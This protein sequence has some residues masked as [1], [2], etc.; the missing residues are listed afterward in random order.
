[1]EQPQKLR[2]IITVNEFIRRQEKLTG[3][4][5][6]EFSGLLMD[7]ILASKIVH[8]EVNKAGLVNILGTEGSANVSGDT[9]MKLDVFANEQFLAALE[10]GGHCL[11]AAS[12]ELEGIVCFEGGRQRGAR[13]IVALDPLDGSSNIDVNVSIGTIF[14]VFRVD[15]PGKLVTEKDFLRPGK[16]LVAAGY[17]LYGS[18]TMLVFTT[19]QS[20][21]GFTLDPSLGEYCLSHPEIRTPEVGSIYSVNEANLNDMPEGVKNYLA[22]CK[23]KN[24]PAGKVHT[25][26]Y[27][28]SLVADFHRN[29]LKGGIYLY[30]ATAKDP[31]GKLRLLYECA[32]LGFICEQAGGRA[33]DGNRSVLE[34]KPDTL[35]QRCPLFIGSAAMVRH[36]ESFL[37]G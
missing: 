21:N 16:E 29:L 37:N 2:S 34:L 12:E 13:Y 31:Q 4:A 15:E 36:A 19:G 17:V 1:M 30:P 22:S 25:A 24:N 3:V 5:T 27:I 32:P 20:V 28:G 35:H 14:A 11:A 9:Q 18:S 26:R 6:G 10:V 7:L 33:S 23:T 8:R